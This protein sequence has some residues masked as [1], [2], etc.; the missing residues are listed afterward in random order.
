MGRQ[1]AENGFC[2]LNGYF[3]MSNNLFMESGN[4]LAF[5]LVAVSFILIPLFS[6]EIRK[7]RSIIFGYWFVIFLHQVV[8][9]LNYYL[10][11]IGEETGG[12]FGASNDANRSFHLISKEL[13]LQGEIIY[14]G[15][16][17]SIPLSLDSFLKGGAFY[18]EML[19]SVYNWFGVSLLLGEQLSILVFGFSCII[20]LRI[21]RILGLERN[22]FS[23]L[24]FFGTLPSM[25]LLGSITLR[26]TYEVFFFMLT[27]YFGIRIS[28]E[29]KLKIGFFFLMTISA[30]LMAAFHKALVVYAIVLIFLFLIWTVRPISRFGNIKKLH[31]LAM[32]VTPLFILGIVIVSGLEFRSFVVLERLLQV[33]WTID[34]WAQRIIEWRIT[35]MDAWARTNYNITLDPSSFFMLIFSS[36]K[37]YVYYLFAGFTWRFNNY[38][39]AYATVEVI[40]RIT[41]TCFSVLSWWRAVGLQKR[42]LGLMLALY[43][44][45]TLM[46]AMGTTNYGTAIRHHMLTWWIIVIL[47]V[48]PLIAKLQ[49]VFLCIVR[50]YPGSSAKIL[51]N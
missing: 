38:N 32:M 39:D 16:N 37:V 8:A 22:S 23:S 9:F 7:N 51:D 24:I 5:C 35:A 17:I 15:Q 28:M 49:P 33:D 34:M 3:V 19:G 21:M 10:Y 46:W 2:L 6:H 40:L 44:S 43:I 1:C 13:A 50:R 36:I 29:R 41:L 47:G 48:P 18:Y 42:L 30:L 31:I 20:F 27:V 11:T 26:E 12:T 45:M 4:T 14:R 25:V